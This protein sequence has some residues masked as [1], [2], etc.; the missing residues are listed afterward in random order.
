MHPL[1]IKAFTSHNISLSDLEIAGKIITHSPTSKKYLTRL[2]IGK[3]LD[4][5]KGEAA[6]LIAM[7]YTSNDLAPKLLALEMSEDGKEG[8]MISQYWDLGGSKSN[9]E[10]QKELARRIAT[11]HTPPTGS[12]SVSRIG[13]E[14]DAR[15]TGNYGFGVSTHCGITELDNTWEESW[16]VFYRD[17]RLGDVIKRI[18]DAQINEEW[19]KMQEK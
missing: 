12:T 6:G 15:Y 19:E 2:A 11:M 16:E 17:R 18:D 10:Y 14:E 1:L 13:I 4:Q 8:A 3:D 7:N 9:P 5:M